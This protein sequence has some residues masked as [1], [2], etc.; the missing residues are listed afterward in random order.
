[1]INKKKTIK[2]YS[3]TEFT[4]HEILK[5]TCFYYS[6]NHCVTSFILY[7]AVREVKSFLPP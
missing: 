4:D 2:T 1:M 3:K 6:V 7:L 5:F